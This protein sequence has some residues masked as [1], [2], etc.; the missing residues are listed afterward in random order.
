MTYYCQAVGCDNPAQYEVN[1]DGGLLVCCFH[2]Q[3][4]TNP[5]PAVRLF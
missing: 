3:A 2:R 1:L 5:D 4:L